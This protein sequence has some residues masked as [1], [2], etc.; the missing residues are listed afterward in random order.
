MLVKEILAESSIFGK[1][2]N[3]VYTL[4]LSTIDAGP[5]DGGCVVVAQAL[6]MAYGGEIVVLV[7]SPRKELAN[8]NEAQHAAVFLNGML[9][10]G[11]GP[12][13]PKQFVERFARNEME[14]AG[15]FITGVRPIRP[16]DLTEAPRNEVLAKKI[17]A[18][19]RPV[20]Y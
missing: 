7:G 20:K 16:R 13:P 18:L 4:L 6:Q 17:A 19:L 8:R 12:L 11:D 14:Y 9:I 3:K 2:K 1:N 5:F 15:G 10:D